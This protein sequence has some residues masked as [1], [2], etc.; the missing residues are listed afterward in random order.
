MDVFPKKTFNGQQV[1]EKM[2]LGYF[3]VFFFFFFFIAE[4]CGLRDLHSPTRIEPRLSAEKVWTPNH[5]TTREFLKRYPI[6]VILRV[7][8]TKTTVNYHLTPVR[9][10]VN[11][12]IRNS[13]CVAMVWRKGGSCAL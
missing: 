5:W 10:A 9:I 12:K 8:Q 6:S 13:K 11:K 4:L 7:M 3:L 1:H 2:V